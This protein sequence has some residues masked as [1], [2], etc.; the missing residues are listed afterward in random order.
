[1]NLL[2]L[3]PIV[4]NY[5]TFEA[6]RRVIAADP[7]QAVDMGG[8][9]T[10]LTD[11]GFTITGLGDVEWSAVEIGTDDTDGVFI[12]EDPAERLWDLYVP[13]EH[14]THDVTH[15]IT[16]EAAVAHRRRLGLNPQP[17]R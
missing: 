4:G 8:I 12:A 1:M 11:A 17:G 9:T 2:P 6:S 15:W 16:Y 10:V 7:D 13:N 5:G 3:Y 14:G